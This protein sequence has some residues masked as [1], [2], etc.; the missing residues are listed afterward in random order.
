MERLAV[1]T[2]GMTHSGKTT[3]ANRLAEVLP[4]SVVI[5]Q[6]IQARFLNTHYPM[7][8][9]E[10][11]PNEIKHA[12][13]Q[14]IV[15]HAV[16]KTSLHLILSNSNLGT[17]SRRR[18]LAYYKD[19]GFVTVLVSFDLEE[20]RLRRRIRESTRS[21]DIFRVSLSYDGLLDRQ[22][23]NFPGVQP[24]PDEADHVLTIK[25]EEDVQRVINRIL[26]ITDGKGRR[27]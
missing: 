21:T 13:T 19:Q 27:I 20:D 6:D 4:G 9:P 16:D 23:K 17:E 10:Q 12:L 7:L 2:A 5:D 26:E 1:M 24:E 14:C 18:W 3:F 15:E 25:S 11:G 8:L 22:M